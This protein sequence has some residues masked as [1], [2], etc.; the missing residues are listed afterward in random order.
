MLATVRPKAV[1]K[2]SAILTADLADD[3]DAEPVLAAARERNAVPSPPFVPLVY[4]VVSFVRSSLG[5]LVDWS[6]GPLRVLAG[7]LVSPVSPVSHVSLVF[8]PCSVGNPTRFV[9]KIRPP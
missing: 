1:P 4:F 6:P 2:G 7:G 3:A 8:R 9:S 5:P